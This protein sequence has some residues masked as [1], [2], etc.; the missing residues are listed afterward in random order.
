[1]G[2]TKSE[3]IVSAGMNPAD[4]FARTHMV[5]Y[6]SDLAKK[7][8]RIPSRKGVPRQDP[9]AGRGIPGIPSRV[10][11]LNRQQQPFFCAPSL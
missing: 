1:M 7:T 6:L 11:N 2:E 3:T 5:M 4:N 8:S 10:H 9:G